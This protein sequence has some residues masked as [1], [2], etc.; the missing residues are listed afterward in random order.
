MSKAI[1]IKK[2][3]VMMSPLTWINDGFNWIATT[4]T[5]LYTAVAALFFATL[6][7]FLPIKNMVQLVILFFII[8][9]LVGYWTAR[10]IRG[11]EWDSKI[12]WKKTMPRAGFSVFFIMGTYMSDLI[13]GQDFFCMYKVVGWLISS[14]IMVSISK[15]AYLLTGWTPFKY[16][17]SITKREIKNKTDMTEKDYENIS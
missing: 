5:D 15:N 13:F 14:I 7:F 1:N 17:G 3:T 4:I 12:V 8:D 2:P 6:G 9:M 16:I 11:E 10:K